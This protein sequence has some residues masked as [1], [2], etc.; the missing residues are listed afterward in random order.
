MAALA[1]AFCAVVCAAAP[2]GAV[3]C[4]AGFCAK[5]VP[6]E[7][8]RNAEMTSMAAALFMRK[9]LSLPSGN[10]PSWRAPQPS[11]R[12]D[13]YS[14]GHWMQIRRSRRGWKKSQAQ[15]AARQRPRPLQR[16]A[17]RSRTSA[18]AIFVALTAGRAVGATQAPDAPYNALA[19]VNNRT[20]HGH[21][22]RAAGGGVQGS[23]WDRER[24]FPIPKR[25]MQM[26][27]VPGAGW[28]HDSR[29][30]ATGSPWLYSA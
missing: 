2:C 26:P 20:S 24:F 8:T 23:D 6:A 5:P 17:T 16:P 11:S 9:F 13:V 19:R 28:A 25:G 10:N 12:G 18:V 14:A 29:G 22:K 3:D 27:T 4:G 7:T 21:R 1:A 15:G 30:R